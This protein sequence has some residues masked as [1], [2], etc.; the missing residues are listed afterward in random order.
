MT[1]G[2]RGAWATA[3]VVATLVLLTPAFYNR[4]PVTFYDSGG[5]IERWFDLTVTMGRSL[6]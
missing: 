1:S 5:Y 6:A 2:E 4:F 3:G